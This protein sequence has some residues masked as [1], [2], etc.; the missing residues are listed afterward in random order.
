MHRFQRKME[1]NFVDPPNRQ[2]N[3]AFSPA[4]CPSMYKD[5]LFMDFSGDGHF[6]VGSTDVTATFWQGSLQVFA[7]F[8]DYNSAKHESFYNSPI[9]FDGKFLPNN[10]QIISESE[11]K[12]KILS[13][14]EVKNDNN[15]ACLQ[16]EDC[17]EHSEVIKQISLWKDENKVLTASD[18]HISQWD[19]SSNLKQVWDFTDYHTNVITGVDTKSSDK[20][21]FVSVGR[22]RRA[23]LWDVRTEGVAIELFKNEFCSLTCVA[24]S[25]VD[26]NTVIVGSQAGSMYMLDVKMPQDF[27]TFQNCHKKNIHKIQFE[28][29]SNLLAV[30]GDTNELQVYNCK[31]NEFNLSYKCVDKHRDFLRDA[32]WFNRVLYTCG[33][34]SC[35]IK[36]SF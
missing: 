27:V 30:V 15:E 9:I 1:I 19:I 2:M 34:Q 10:R 6:L 31:G 18:N 33:L 16:I 3:S 29:E 24:W 36:H 25:S 14:A 11:S 5:T 32:K 35:V 28:Q 12:L 4:T 7:S 13:Q 26:E 8:D 21:L 22:D 23:C 17:V 20:N